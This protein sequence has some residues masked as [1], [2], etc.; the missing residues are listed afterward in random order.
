MRPLADL[1]DEAVNVLMYAIDHARPDG[2]VPLTTR[3]IGNAL[4]LSRRQVANRIAILGSTGHLSIIRI[5]GRA[6]VYYIPERL[7]VISRFT[8]TSDSA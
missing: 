1:A 5:R 8:R 7:Q 2:L 6:S 3:E 4:Q